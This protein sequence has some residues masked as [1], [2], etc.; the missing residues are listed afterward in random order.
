MAEKKENRKFHL[1]LGIIVFLIIVIYLLVYSASYLFKDKL[2]V[3]EVTASDIAD[4]IEGTG[5]AVRQEHVV[6]SEEEGYIN[7]YVKNGTRVEEKGT[8]Y[9]VDQTGKV[10]EYLQDLLK[11]ES[12]MNSEEKQEILEDLKTFSDS[13]SDSSFQTVYSSFSD[14]DN[15]MMAYTDQLLADNAEDIRKKYGDESISEE[16]SQESG[17]VTF[18][19]DGMESLKEED[20]TKDT[21]LKSSK[22]KD[23]RSTEKVMKGS[24]VYRITT[25]QNWKLIMSVSDSEYERMNKLIEEGTTTIKV[26]IEKDDFETTVPFQCQYRGGNYYVILSFEN[27]VQRYINQRFLKLTL[28]LSETEGLTVPSSAITYKEAYKIPKE[29]LV[30]GGDSTSKKRVNVL[31]KKG[32][33]TQQDVTVYRTEGDDIL[34]SSK[35]LKDGQTIATADKS[36]QF[37]LSG[38]TKVTGVFMVNR[39]YAIFVQVQTL[40]SNEEYCIVEAENQADSSSQVLE[41]YDRII[42]NSSTV[43]E[44]QIIY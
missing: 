30:S 20:I 41:L 43:R 12:E 37:T 34:V 17:I 19:S 39:G 21:F 4:S 28:L 9:S 32:R 2:A 3:Y 15:H 7:Y 27:Y 16:K 29:Y 18:T 33:L 35:K 14:I 36:K 5:I 31:D 38:T 1:N 25:S 40:K 10:Q 22:M 44:N 24:P 26:T 23:L 42:L 8:V 13:Y 11:D 6:N